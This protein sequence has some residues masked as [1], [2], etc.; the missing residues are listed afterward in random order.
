[1]DKILLVSDGIIF[2]VVAGRDELDLQAGNVGISL[3]EYG[4]EIHI[5]NKTICLPA[6]VL[7]HLEGSDETNIYFYE[8]DP[9]HL[10][11]EYKGKIELN[12]DEILKVKGAWEYQAPS[13]NHL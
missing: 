11:A 10:V 12:R 4:A 3:A 5:S 6:S 13:Q 8:S 7:A 9:Y 2:I 1:M